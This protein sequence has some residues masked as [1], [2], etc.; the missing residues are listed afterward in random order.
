MVGKTDFAFIIGT[1]RSG[2]TLL[3]QMLNSHSRICVPDELQILFEVSGNGRRLYE[4]FSAGNNEDY[5]AADYIELVKNACPHKLDMYYD[6][7]TFFERQDYPARSMEDLVCA[8]YADIAATQNK[9]IFIEQTPWYGQ[10]IEVLNELFPDAKYIHVIRDGRDVAISFSRSPWWHDDVYENLG[11]WDEEINK[12]IIDSKQYLNKGQ[13]LEIRYEDIISDPELTLGEVCRHLGVDFDPNILDPDRYVDY[14]R[15][16]K[17]DTRDSNPSDAFKN[18]NK[19]KV[20]PVFKGSRF[21][22]K[23]NE[24]F[25]FSN[26]SNKL[27]QTLLSLGYEG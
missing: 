4:V 12:I 22:W 9:D 18:W 7:R 1:G 6:Y 19:K 10:R 23:N 3:A 5:L 2:T 17:F 14:S 21:A 25:D 27:S 8:L 26:L 24:E 13:M 20:D 11:R 16:S 15:Y